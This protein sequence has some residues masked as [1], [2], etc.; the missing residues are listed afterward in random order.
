MINAG[1]S[2]LNEDQAS[3]DVLYVKKLTSKQQRASVLLEDSG[4]RFTRS[5]PTQFG[6]RKQ[7]HLS[8]RFRFLIQFLTFGL[9]F[10]LAV[11]LPK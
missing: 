8:F 9:Q 5:R 3:C 7:V 1:K 10:Y 2:M 11:Q 4:V 6:H